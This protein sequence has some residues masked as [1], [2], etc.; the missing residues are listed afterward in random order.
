MAG[1][2]PVAKGSKGNA[3]PGLRNKDA[4]VLPTSPRWRCSSGAVN[5]IALSE[6]E[7]AWH[8]CP[9]NYGLLSDG[10]QRLAA[11]VV[12]RWLTPAARRSLM[13]DLRRSPSGWFR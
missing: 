5:P 7:T 10:L 1:Y 2:K 3:G 11:Q 12:L 9:I 13:N 4:L 8:G 6:D